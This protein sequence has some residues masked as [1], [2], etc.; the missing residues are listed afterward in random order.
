[1]TAY[2]FAL[3]ARDEA[4]NESELSNPANGSTAVSPVQVTFSFARGA[5]A[6]AWSPVDQGILYVAGVQGHEQVQHLDFSTGTHIE[7]TLVP[8]FARSPSWS[9]DGSHLA[10]V[11]QSAASEPAGVWVMP[12]AQYAA[13]VLVATESKRRASTCSWSQSRIAYSV[14][15]QQIPIRLSHIYVVPSGGGASAPIVEDPSRN[16]SPS[17]SPDGTRITFSST[18]SGNYDIWVT[19]ADGTGLTQLTFASADDIEPDWSPD[20]TRIAFSS[21]RSGNYDI[22]VMSSSGEILGQLDTNSADEFGPSWSPDGQE[23]SFTSNRNGLED[24]WIV[25][26]VP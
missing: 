18:R 14:F 22:W 15:V 24:I 10:F 25:S 21:A 19:A 2:F 5:S 4:G 9:P 3:R 23:V 6:S 11:T 8:E 12:T 17:W 20:G 7:M 1:M 13:P 16:G 26:S